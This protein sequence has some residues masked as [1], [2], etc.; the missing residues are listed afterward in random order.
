MGEIL[1]K[2]Y[3]TGNDEVIRS[4]DYSIIRLNNRGNTYAK[5]VTRE[6]DVINEIID[7]KG[8]LKGI[9]IIKKPSR[10]VE[11]IYN[12]EKGTVIVII[13]DSNGRKF[14]GIA[15]CSKGEEFNPTIGYTIAYSRAEIKQNEERI[16]KYMV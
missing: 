2:R 14:K 9:D 10:E 12:L 16:N 6:V 11:T 5:H 1:I 8:N 3:K 13:K 15:K 7:S 4:A